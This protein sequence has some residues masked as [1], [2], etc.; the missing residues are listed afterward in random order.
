MVPGPKIQKLF[1][2]SIFPDSSREKVLTVLLLE[3]VVVR[4]NAIGVL[5][6]IASVSTPRNYSNF[7]LILEQYFL[8]QLMILID[9][10]TTN[11]VSSFY[12]Q[13]SNSVK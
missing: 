1:S 5:K 12:S 8:F 13:H 6:E 4:C 9:L 3:P 2:S 10:Q 7:H 11:Y